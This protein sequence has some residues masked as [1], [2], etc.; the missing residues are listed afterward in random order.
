MGIKGCSQKIIDF[1]S[2]NLFLA[3]LSKISE[4]SNLTLHTF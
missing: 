4:H 1:S 2:G 3:I